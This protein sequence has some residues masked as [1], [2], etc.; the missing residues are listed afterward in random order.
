LLLMFHGFAAEDHVLLR[1]LGS[2][3]L[4]NRTDA[5]RD[6]VLLNVRRPH[7][8]RDDEDRHHSAE[9]E[10]EFVAIRMTRAHW[11]LL[12]PLSC[13]PAR[14]AKSWLRQLNRRLCY[15]SPGNAQPDFCRAGCALNRLK[16]NAA[17]RQRLDFGQL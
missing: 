7:E 12:C 5:A 6:I 8:E 17:V 15:L 16:N 13:I 11:N 10:K 2:V 9:T 4:L 1:D 3:V 14:L